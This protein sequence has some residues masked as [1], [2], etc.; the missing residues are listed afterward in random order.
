MRI[1]EEQSDGMSSRAVRKALKRLEQE[2]AAKKLN[3][4]S[5]QDDVSE[6]EEEDHPARPPSNPFAMVSS[7]CCASQ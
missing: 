3:K 2:E 5:A 7:I 1:R 4:E 6:D